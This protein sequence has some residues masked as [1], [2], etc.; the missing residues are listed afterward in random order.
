MTKIDMLAI[1]LAK[2]SFQV[3]AVGPEGGI[4]TRPPGV[5]EFVV[6]ARRRAVE[7]MTNSSLS[8]KP[9]HVQTC[10]WRDRYMVVTHN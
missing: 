3:C 6:I 5:T 9:R 4:Q 10:F 7:R 2:G 8:G 1:D